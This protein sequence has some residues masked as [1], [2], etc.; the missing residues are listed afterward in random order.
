MPVSYN[1]ELLSHGLFMILISSSS[2]T[3]SYFTVSWLNL[4]SCL[5]AQDPRL[6]LTI[7]F[8]HFTL[9]TREKEGILL[10]EIQ[11]DSAFYMYLF[12]DGPQTSTYYFGRN[13]LLE[14]NNQHMTTIEN[15][16]LCDNLEELWNLCRSMI[17]TFYF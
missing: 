17:K 9:F 4:C 7:E 2:L 11:K 3:F 10:E 13:S 16:P 12:I 5:T 14:F 6:P 15:F 8:D 1:F